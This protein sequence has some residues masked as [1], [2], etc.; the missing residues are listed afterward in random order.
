MDPYQRFHG[1]STGMYGQPQQVTI[2]H[3]D[4]TVRDAIQGAATGYALA[5]VRGER[6]AAEVA[7]DAALPVAWKVF[8]NVFCVLGAFYWVV[9]VVI[10]LGSVL[11]SAVMSIVF[12]IEVPSFE[13]GLGLP[14]GNY[15]EDE[16]S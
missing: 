9:L 2:K 12:G 3:V 4:N 10:P 7:A 14:I 13:D 1:A 15:K 8:R 16:Y 5:H 6:T 11:L